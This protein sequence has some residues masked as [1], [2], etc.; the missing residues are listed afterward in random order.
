MKT[1][2]LLA[3]GLLSAMAVTTMSGTSV[4]A[5]ENEMSGTGSTNVE[6]TP[7]QS[8]GGDGDGNVSSWTVD[9]PVKI[10]LS[11]ATKDAESGVAINF[12][13]VKTGATQTPY[14]GEAQVTATLAAHD[15]ATTDGNSIK[16][17]DTLNS[18][19]LKDNVTMQLAD[20]R[21]K[22]VKT[23]DQSTPFTT[24]NKTQTTYALSAYLSNNSGAENK[25][26]YKT[27][28]TWNFHSNAY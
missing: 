5:S 27:T 13:L 19:A 6:Y 20:E 7:G 14:D 1:K 12:G 25:K 24:L 8:S 22:V 16:M 10:T 11:D 3:L 21:K 23:N 15:D 17:Q 4:F 9:Y 18:N 28:L 2:K 26:T